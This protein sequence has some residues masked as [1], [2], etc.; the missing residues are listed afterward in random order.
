M[1]IAIVGIIAAI[2]SFAVT[3]RLLLPRLV[4][5]SVNKLINDFYFEEVKPMQEALDIDYPEAFD[6]MQKDID[7]IKKLVDD[8]YSD[9]QYQKP[10]ESFDKIDALPLRAANPKV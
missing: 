3:W 1:E 7:K 9:G 10:R 6:D 4:D 8:L 5:K 2:I